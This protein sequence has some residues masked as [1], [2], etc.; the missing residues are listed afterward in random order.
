LQIEHSPCLFHVIQAISKIV[1]K[2]TSQAMLTDNQ[3]KRFHSELKKKRLAKM[4]ANRI[5]DTDKNTKRQ[6]I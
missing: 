5:K 6:F 1:E 2:Q 4:L 3:I